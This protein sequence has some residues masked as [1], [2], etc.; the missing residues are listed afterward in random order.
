[1]NI[2]HL[3][4]GIELPEGMTHDRVMSMRTENGLVSAIEVVEVVPPAFQGHHPCPWDYEARRG[5]QVVR[6]SSGHAT[7][8]AVPYTIMRTFVRADGA[9]HASGDR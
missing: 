9:W 7:I 4:E 2:Q 8:I 6:Y 5:E 1:M 3:L